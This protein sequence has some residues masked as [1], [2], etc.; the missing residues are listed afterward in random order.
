MINITLITAIAPTVA[1]LLATIT[2]LRNAKKI[3]EVHVSLNGRLTQLLASTKLEGQS[4]GRREERDIQAARPTREAIAANA[5]A[6][7]AVATAIAAAEVLSVAATAA[8]K[9]ENA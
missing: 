9:K 6:S 2:S 8:D 3:Q 5:A 7:V 1:A 4:E